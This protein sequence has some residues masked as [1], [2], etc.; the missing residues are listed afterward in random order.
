M[1]AQ[2]T[3][4]RV[5]DARAAG[6]PDALATAL[7]EQANALV[8][9]G[10]V[11]DAR[12]ALD[13]AA[14]IHR[15]RGRAYDEARCLQ[16]A[17]T[18]C[19]MEGLPDEAADRA[20]RA[21]DLAGPG[22]QIGVSA[23]TELGEIALQRRDGPAAADAYGRALAAGA[24]LGMVGSARAA[25][26]RK[27]ATALSI[28]GRYSDAAADLA[29]AHDLLAQAGDARGATR[30]LV[31]EATA[32]H[33][34]GDAAGAARVGDEAMREAAQQGDHAAEADLFMLRAAA[35]L[36]HNDPAVAKRALVAARDQA[37]QG[38]APV[39]YL[40]AAVALSQLADATGDR[41]GAYEALATGWATLGDLLGRDAAKASFEPKLLEL[42][43]RWGAAAFDDVKAQYEARRRAALAEQRNGGPPDAGERRA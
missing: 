15:E 16:F 29:R 33:G 11:H 34:A 35:A 18:L 21:I 31:E 39:Q 36:G 6:D 37:L 10:R 4:R 20:R 38:T 40:S 5:A 32:L 7:A 25:L 8:Q 9:R 13:E 30:A 3:E 14:S 28:A 2:D 41:L 17:A 22:S 1:D 19:R 43:Q 23:E 24:A 27:R 26:L 42:R 12:L